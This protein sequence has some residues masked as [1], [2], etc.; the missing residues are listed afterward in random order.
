MDESLA[1]LLSDLDGFV[2]KREDGT[3]ETYKAIAHGEKVRIFEATIC[4]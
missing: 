1:K 2:K 3:S 4:S